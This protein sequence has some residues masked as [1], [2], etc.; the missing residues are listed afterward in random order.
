[1]TEFKLKSRG[2]HIKGLKDTVSVGS[3]DKKIESIF[4]EVSKATKLPE[5][6]LRLLVN[7]RILKK[8]EDI[9]S[10]YDEE[11]IIVKDLGP[12]IGWKTVFLAEYLGPLCIHPLVYKSRFIQGLLY[13]NIVKHSYNQRIIFVL[14]VLH[15]VK[16]EL[17]TLLVHRFSMN[18]MPRMNLFK[19]CFHYWVLGGINMAYWMYGP[20][21]SY[22]YE[23][24]IILTSYVILWMFSEYANLKTHLILRNLRPKKT[25][26]R[27]IPKGF[28]FD[29]VSCPN[30]FF[31]YISWLV[32]ACLSHS[33]SSWIFL[34]VSGI[35]MWLWALKKHS[36]Y[37][38]EFSDYPKHR[39]VMFPYI[40]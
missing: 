20:W 10:I 2:R 19:N 8:E 4:K 15:Y 29:L 6:R 23:S 38:K 27:Q 16:R 35:Q 12:Q 11:Y 33:L 26:V 17:E 40:L 37:I 14:I 28:G 18:T 9:N 3:N 1:M 39:K 7:E 13:G 25:T 30:Y 5:N 24:K 22:I 36:R 32:I 21:F 34:T 31:E